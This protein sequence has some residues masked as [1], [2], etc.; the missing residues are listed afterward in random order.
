MMSSFGERLLCK[1]CCHQA[2]VDAAKPKRPSYLSAKTIR[3]WGI[4]FTIIAVAFYLGVRCV[5]LMMRMTKREKPR[6]VEGSQK[7][8]KEPAEKWP[9]LSMAIAPSE[10][11]A[12]P[13]GWRLG[14]NACLVERNDGSIICV[15]G[16][17]ERP[18]WE[19]ALASTDKKNAK[20]HVQPEAPSFDQLSRMLTAC[21]L[22]SSDGGA[23]FTKLLPGARGA[24]ERGV[25]V[26]GEPSGVVPKSWYSFRMSDSAYAPGMKMIVLARDPKTGAQVPLEAVVASIALT[27]DQIHRIG[28]RSDDGSENLFTLSQPYSVD[29]LIGAPVVDARGHLAAVITLAFAP[30]DVGGRTTDFI[31]FGMHALKPVAGTALTKNGK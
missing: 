11:S 29:A 27:A 22:T 2:E 31:A 13:E 3:N 28:R 8:A 30:T 12:V 23:T 1:P 4:F 10:G 20:P 18:S 17:A 9:I 14:P 6:G 15:T 25:V 24:F 7:W 16:V 26:F 5:P 21:H 19:N